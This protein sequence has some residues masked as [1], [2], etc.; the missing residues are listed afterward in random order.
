MQTFFQG[1]ILILIGLGAGFVVA[2]GVVAF[3]SIIGIIPIIGYRTKTSHYMMWYE[4]MVILGSIV[5]SILTC[6][7][8]SLPI[9]PIFTMLLLFAYGIF[10]G[11]LIIAL[12]EV[13][14]VFPIINRRIKL[15]KCISLIVIAIAMGKLVGSLCY[16][17]YP[18]FTEVYLS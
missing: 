5:G 3:I 14:D 6:W 15:K 11:V 8:I 9:G 10:I 7:E 16:W 2:G 1:I 12:A 17:I 18:Y 4:N 13:L